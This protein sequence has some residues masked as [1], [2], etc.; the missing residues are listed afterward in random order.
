MTVPARVRVVVT[1]AGGK[2]GRAVLAAVR[3]RGAAATG[4]VRTPDHAARLPE[5]VDAVVGDQ[6]DAALLARALEGADAVHLIAPN[7]SPDDVAMAEAAVAA[8]AVAG[9]RRAVLHSVVHPQLTAMPHHADKARAE[10]VLLA[11]DVA[12]TLLQPNAYVQN[13]LGDPGSLR[14]G[15]LAVPYDVDARSALVD[16]ADVAEVASRCL[17]DGLGVHATFE[18]SGPAEVSARDVAAAAATALGRG[19]TAER[20]DPEEWV[21]GAAPAGPAG[22]ERRRRLLAMVRH[23][24]RH[25]SPG[26]A[27]V[28]RALLGREPT[29]MPAVVAR[30]LAGPEGGREGRS[31]SVEGQRPEGAGGVAPT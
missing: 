5:G 29:A 3:A 16:L 10:E 25:G 21:A 28:L 2:T 19:V 26:D 22:E 30:V 24:D 20:L 4:V 1:G 8:C 23:Y 11:S 13:L 27:T 12:W 18:L 31:G 7:M 6:R 17:L 9:V 14:A 15:R